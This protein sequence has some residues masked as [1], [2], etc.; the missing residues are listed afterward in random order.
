[1]PTFATKPGDL[2]SSN[3]SKLRLYTLKKAHEMSSRVHGQV[4]TEFRPFCKSLE[5][6]EGNIPSG[7]PFI[8]LTALPKRSALAVSQPA[9]RS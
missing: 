4:A 2:L 8:H 9:S 3:S 6:L 5:D 1:M 7:H